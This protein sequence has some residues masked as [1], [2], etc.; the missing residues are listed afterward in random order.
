M[1]PNYSAFRGPI[2]KLANI[3]GITPYYNLSRQKLRYTILFKFHGLFLVMLSLTAI[4][5]SYYTLRNEPIIIS[6]LLQSLQLLLATISTLSFLVLILRSSFSKMKSWER[7]LNLL[8]RTECH[9]M[10]SGRKILYVF[11]VVCSFPGLALFA[12]TLVLNG[13]SYAG[14]VLIL[15]FTRHV[16]ICLMCNVV[17]I[18][19]NKYNAIDNVL[20]NLRVL[21]VIE[22]GTAMKIKDLQRTYLEADK[23]VGYFNAIFGWPLLLLFAETVLILLLFLAIVTEHGFKVPLDNIMSGDIIGFQT[24]YSITVL[25]SIR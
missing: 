15:Y 5:T 8:A 16:A 10:R 1:S 9:N 2:F 7:M 13:I 22:S 4:I 6:P 12:F 23:I 24:V 18:L 21:T 14:P 11:L 3:F 17:D 20:D 19:K 25:V